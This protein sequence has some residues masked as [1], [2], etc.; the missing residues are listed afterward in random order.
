MRATTASPV[1]A[2]THKAECRHEMV[3]RRREFLSLLG[4]AGGA[5]GLAGCQNFWVVPE[6]LVSLALR[7]PGLE[8]EAQTICGLCEGGCGV[9]VRLVDG[10]P[11]GVKGNLNHPLNRGGLCP[12]GQAA[13]EILY[14]PHRLRGPMEKTSS[15][16]HRPIGWEDALGR[17]A[18]VLDRLV[19]AGEGHRI[20][21]LTAE[22]SEL[23]LG[24]AR[25]FTLAVGSK[26]F[27]RMEL[28]GSLAYR[29]T[30]GLAGPPGFDLSRSDL[31]LSFGLDL[32]EDGPAPMHA[33]S[34]LV[35]ERDN[36]ALASVLHVGTRLSPSGAK[37]ERYVRIAPDTHGAFALGVAN[38]LV[39]EGRIDRDF[40]DRRTFG[41]EDW[42]QDGRR[43]LGFRRLLLERYYPDRVGQLCGCD[44]GVVVR[45]ARRFAQSSRPLAMAGGEAL[46][47]PN[48][49][50]NGMAVH[51]LNA[52]LGVFDRPGGVV[53]PQPIPLTSLPEPEGARDLPDS[54]FAARPQAEPIFGV[55]P[56]H[57]LVE[58][59]EEDPESVEVLFLAGADPIHE[60]P[61][62]K[63]L[64]EVMDRIPMLVALTPFLDD[65][66][67]RADLILPTHTYLESWQSST[68]PN[69]S[70]F[71]VLGLAPPVVEPLFD[72]RHPGDVLL[73][74]A[75]QATTLQIPWTSYNEYLKYRLEG[76]AVSGQGSILSGSFEESWKHFLEER[77]W[78]F[79]EHA[80]LEDF[81]DDLARQSGWWN[82]VPS[83]AD[84]ERMFRHDSHRY[85]FFSTT[86]EKR[87]I[88]LGRKIDPAASEA[89]ALQAA[90]RQ[91]RLGADPDEV[92]LPH[93]EPPGETPEGELALVPF[94]P[95][96]A[97]GRLGTASPMLMEMFGYPVLSGW[98]TWAEMDPE[99]A[100]RWGIEDGDQVALETAEGSIEVTVHLRP[101]AAPGVVHV[102]LGLGRRSGAGAGVGANPVELM[103]PVADPLSG[104][105][106]HN[107][108]SVRLRLLRRRPRGGPAP[109]HSGESI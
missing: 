79:S 65:T 52:L 12:L 68:T 76:L 22:P 47:G 20:A 11:V 23:F 15:G 99:T 95:I 2:E 46:R 48:A 51:A 85:E 4:V 83:P 90:C 54:M 8:S 13:L 39:R 18:E 106:A 71:S 55:D 96:T 64:D 101:G 70:A 35:G 63:R 3:L 9:R 87:L 44:P 40:V 42:T 103:T 61:A 72:T 91:L 16:E 30:Q 77:G 98:R 1:T 69:F 50:W 109:S 86:L 19:S 14:S 66:A 56:C 6:E 58:C 80:G 94:R 28:E 10:I 34:A 89:Q 105:L 33:I 92:C 41:F 84:W 62:G 100:H 102:P 78:R 36:E 88:A 38:V 82:P 60:S 17:I 5:A 67:A 27:G 59:L 49:T 107:A 21:L 108:T 53:L 24:L 81:W 29:L 97:R 7:G 104:R 45:V 93:F 25:Y 75:R 26:N 43:R 31:V 57:A 73:Q 74:L 37:A 32:F